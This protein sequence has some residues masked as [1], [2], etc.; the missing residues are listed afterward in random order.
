M[1]ENIKLAPPWITYYHEVKALFEKDEEVKITYNEENYELS[2]YVE[3]G[4]KADALTQ[5]F[6]TEK[7]FGNV[8]MKIKVIPANLGTN[9]SQLFADA[10]YGNSA[11]KEIDNFD[12]VFGPMSY[13]V[14]NREVVQFY[15]DQMDDINGNK[16][17]LYQEIAK[18]VFEDH[19]GVY[20]CTDAPAKLQKPL[21]EWP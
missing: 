9:Y 5:L 18:D 14:F 8:K 3:N 21:G 12:T 4:R 15:N 20:F 13:V 1:A 19:Q 6:P 11:V 7:E 17:T 10:F 2:I 16:S